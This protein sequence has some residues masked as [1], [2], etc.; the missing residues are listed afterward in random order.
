MDRGAWWATVHGITKMSAPLLKAF[1]LIQASLDCAHEHTV[2]AAITELG[3][4]GQGKLGMVS[5]GGAVP[6]GHSA[7]SRE[8]NIAAFQCPLPYWTWGWPGAGAACLPGPVSCWGPRKCPLELPLPLPQPCLRPL[9]KLI[10]SSILSGKI[11]WAE[12]PGG[13]QSKGSHR[14]SQD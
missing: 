2:V 6:E 13:L 5:A 4:K 10:Y 14:V 3:C 1:I 8:S 7:H 9:C 11:P 12:E